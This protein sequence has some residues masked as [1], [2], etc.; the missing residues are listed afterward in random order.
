MSF[1]IVGVAA[2]QV[3]N[4]MQQAEI[5]REQGKIA[6]EVAN[7]NAEFAEI[8]AWHAEQDGQTNL[9]RYEGQVDQVISTQKN[10][11]AAK[12]VDFKFGSAADVIADSKLAGMLNGLDIKNEA[13]QKALGYKREAR[14]ILINGA[15]GQAQS[16]AQSSAIQGAAI[17]NAGTTAVSGYSKDS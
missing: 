3:I 14:N 6:R 9:A 7:M 10:E 2:I 16:N 4:G 8:D 11:F 5:V 17:A 15:M 13:H 1:V 12:D